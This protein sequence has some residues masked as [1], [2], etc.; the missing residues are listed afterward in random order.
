MREKGAQEVGLREA[1][2]VAAVAQVQPVRV[3]ELVVQELGVENRRDAMVALAGRAEDA[4]RRAGVVLP[5]VAVRDRVVGGDV[6]VGRAVR[7]DHIRPREGV[8]DDRLVRSV[9]EHHHQRRVHGGVAIEGVEGVGVPIPEAGV[10]GVGVLISASGN[11]LLRQ[12]YGSPRALCAA[13]C[14]PPLPPSPRHLLYPG[15]N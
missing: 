2:P 6:A 14:Q 9:G 8:A 1:Y 11:T 7:L 12:Y 10:E 3:G 4:A 5:E 15:I 13:R